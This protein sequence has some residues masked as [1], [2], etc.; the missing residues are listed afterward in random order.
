V[1]NGR[2]LGVVSARDVL[3]SE[4]REFATEL[5]TREHIEAIL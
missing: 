3:G 2:S 5:Q 4:L 1:E